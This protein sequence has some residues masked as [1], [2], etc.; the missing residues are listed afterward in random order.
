MEFLT[1]ASTIVTGFLIGSVVI[2]AIVLIG[3]ILIYIRE[4]FID[5]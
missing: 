3:Y 1:K 5:N 2:A 4:N